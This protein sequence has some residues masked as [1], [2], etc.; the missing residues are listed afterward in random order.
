[1]IFVYNQGK[2]IGYRFQP[3]ELDVSSLAIVLVFTKTLIHVVCIVRP[4]MLMQG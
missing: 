4:G 1:M 3:K 2:I